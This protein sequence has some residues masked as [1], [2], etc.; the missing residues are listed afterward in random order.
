[1]KN[2]IRQIYFYAATLI[3]LVMAVIAS[4][5]LIDLGL[6]TYVLTDA[7]GA[8]APTCDAT[9]TIRYGID[10]PAPPQ[11]EPTEGVEAWRRAECERL[12]SA[13]R[14]SERQRQLA[15]HLSMLIV[16][17]PLFVL[18]FRWVQ[19]EREKELAAGDGRKA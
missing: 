19:K 2:T 8:Y 18:H 16:A 15:Q 7:D 9:G 13:Q 3:F 17:A 11:A 14:A 10:A 4:V 12:L 1:M 5:A 6:K